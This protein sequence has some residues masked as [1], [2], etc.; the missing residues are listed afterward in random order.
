VVLYLKMLNNVT[1]S[2]TKNLIGDYPGRDEKSN[3][4]F[5][6]NA[7][8]DTFDVSQGA[9]DNGCGVI[10][11]MDVIKVLQHLKLKPRRTL[12]ILLTPN[13][14]NQLGVKQ[15]ISAHSSDIGSHI[16]ALVADSGC[17]RPMGYIFYEKFPKMGCILF[18]LSLLFDKTLT[19]LATNQS[20][21]SGDEFTAANL[22]VALMNGD[23]GRY[24]WVR[25]TAADTMT[26]VQAGDLDQI[27]G[28]WA[29]TA[30]ILADMPKIKDL[31]Q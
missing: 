3:E 13:E 16:G 12:R 24:Y 1:E 9:Q 14:Y 27:L 25:H 5:L 26:H 8:L 17:G 6:L 19:I 10:L 7:H 20:L 30:Y 18:E 2:T 22:P 15:Y 21:T 23:D 4:V 28:F 31:I 29:T 11:A